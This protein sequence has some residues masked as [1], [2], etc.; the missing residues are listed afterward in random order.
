MYLSSGQGRKCG[1]ARATGATP[2]LAP[3]VIYIYVEFGVVVIKLRSTRGSNCSSRAELVRLENCN[4]CLKFWLIWLL[5]PQTPRIQLVTPEIQALHYLFLFWHFQK[6]LFKKK[7][8]WFSR[9]IF[10]TL[11]FDTLERGERVR[12]TYL[13][14]IDRSPASLTSD[15]FIRSNEIIRTKW[16]IYEVI[17]HF[18]L[19]TSQ[20]RGL[21]SIKSSTDVT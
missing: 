5:L 13:S 4:Y 19:H 10:Y 9:W 18:V 2:S 17:S 21:S 3:L 14:H 12:H 15:D 1:G 7:I 16:P 11:D 8:D 6:C 20:I